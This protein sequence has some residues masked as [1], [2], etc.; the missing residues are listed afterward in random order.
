MC[1]KDLFAAFWYTQHS[2]VLRSAHNTTKCKFFR[3]CFEYLNPP[4]RTVLCTR[5]I[6][7]IGCAC[8]FLI[9]VHD[10]KRVCIPSHSLTCCALRQYY[11]SQQNMPSACN[12][13]ASILNTNCVYN[14]LSK[15]ITWTSYRECGEFNLIEGLRMEFWKL[16]VGLIWHDNLYFTR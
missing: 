3:T 5:Q 13:F 4:L 6:I 10:F 8:G 12:K 1:E 11:S 14:S 2:T 9:N 7:S 15:C 16:A